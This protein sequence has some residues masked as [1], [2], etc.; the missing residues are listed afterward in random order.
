MGAFL[1][2]HL[3]ELN[4]KNR[5]SASMALRHPYFCT[6]DQ[7]RETNFNGTA[8]SSPPAPYTDQLTPTQHLMRMEN[9]Y[10][11]DRLPYNQHVDRVTRAYLV[12]WLIEV[13]DVFDTDSRCV[14]LAMDFFSQFLGTRLIEPGKYQLA[15]AACI[16]IASK[17]E[18]NIIFAKF[19]SI[20]DLL[21]CADNTFQQDDVIHMENT[22]LDAINFQIYNPIIFDF[23][24]LY[25]EHLEHGML[26]LFHLANGTSMNKALWMA[27]YISDLALQSDLCRTYAPSLI[28]TCVVS[29]A[30]YCLGQERDVVFSEKLHQV[31]GYESRDMQTC[32]IDLWDNIEYFRISLSKLKMISQGYNRKEKEFVSKIR[33]LNPN[34]LFQRRVT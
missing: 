12:D 27:R 32:I 16:H 26:Q 18:K 3:L 28:A 21:F 24:T 29:L 1:L 22:L 30:L 20:T 17:C 9:K 23:I 13:V 19:I 6:V 34:D 7:M 4:S 8:T 14:Y 25:V 33:I 15:A 31:S 10:I 11:R 5:V 2:T